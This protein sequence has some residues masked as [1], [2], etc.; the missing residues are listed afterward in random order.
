MVKNT[1]VLKL[2]FQNVIMAV[3]GL[4]MKNQ[5]PNKIVIGS[6]ILV[7]CR[8]ESFKNLMAP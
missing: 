3:F 8:L 7:E 5:K 2:N 6:R 4:T 1:P